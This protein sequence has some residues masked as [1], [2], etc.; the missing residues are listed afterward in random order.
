VFGHANVPGMVR[1]FT[2]IELLVAVALMAL[3]AIM[4][5]RG[6]DGMVRG[7]TDRYPRATK[8]C[9]PCRPGLSQWAADL[10]AMTQTPSRRL[11]F[12]GRV[13][14][15]T[16]R[17]PRTP[18]RRAGG[19]LD[20]PLV[21]GQGQWLRWQSPPVTHAGAACSWPG[22]RP[23][24]W[25]QNPATPCDARKSRVVPLDEWQIFYYRNNDAWTNP[26]S[27]AAGAPASGRHGGAD[28]GCPTVCAWC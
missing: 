20:A 11:D 3:L 15:M 9:W 1:G 18:L 12:D 5:W 6:L 13:L 21:D 22:S 28:A 4:S 10:D 25:G 8:R 7:R 27:S 17:S 14:R 16:R 24:M 23:A 26:L 19:G 2:L